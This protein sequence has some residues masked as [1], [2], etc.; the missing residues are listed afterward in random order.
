MMGRVF[1]VHMASTA[2]APH[3][4][5]TV[6]AVILQLGTVHRQLPAGHQSD[7]LLIRTYPANAVARSQPSVSERCSVTKRLFSPEL[8]SLIHRDFSSILVDHQRDHQPHA[9]RRS[10]SLQIALGAA[11]RLPCSCLSPRPLKS[12]PGHKLYPKHTRHEKLIL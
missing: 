5:Q 12:Y 3:A 10:A 8:S 2:S 6:S 7:S 4:R 9:P 11:L 1:G